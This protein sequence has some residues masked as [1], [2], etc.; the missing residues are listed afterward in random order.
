L[1]LRICSAHLGKFGFLNPILPELFFEFLNLKGDTKCP[2]PNRSWKLFTL[3]W[4]DLARF[5]HII[6][7]TDWVYDVPIMTCH[8]VTMTSQ[9][10]RFEFWGR[11]LESRA[12][13]HTAD[14]DNIKKYE[15]VLRNI[16]NQNK[17]TKVKDLLL[18]NKREK[19]LKK[20]LKRQKIVKIHSWVDGCYGNVNHRKHVIDTGQFSLV[21]LGKI[22][23][24]GDYSS[25]RLKVIIR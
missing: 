17:H 4:W 11:H 14:N 8:D 9:T 15:F 20:T 19:K 10:S 12:C 24:I 21:N 16:L 18:K 23:R 25:S 2:P 7:I 5:L 22:T 13:S 6:S 3:L 1:L